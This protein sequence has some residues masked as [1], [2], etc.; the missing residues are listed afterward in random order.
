[1]LREDPNAPQAQVKHKDIPEAANKIHFKKHCEYPFRSTNREVRSYHD[2]LPKDT[3]TVNR[4][5]PDFMKA[6]PAFDPAYSI[7]PE[8]VNADVRK[9]VMLKKPCLDDED[10]CSLERRTVLR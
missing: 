3:P 2:L 1:M 10:V 5:N 8:T 6:H 7:Q 4:Y 9:P